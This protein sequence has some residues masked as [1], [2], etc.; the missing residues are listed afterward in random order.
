M[1]RASS[2]VWNVCCQT[3][4]SLRLRKNRFDDP[5]LFRRIR[6]DELLRQPI[7]PT[8]LPE[9]PTLEDQAVIAPARPAPP[10]AG[11][12]QTGPGRRLPPRAPPPLARLRQRELVADHFPIM[13]QSIT[14]A[15]CAQP[16]AHGNMRHPWPTVRCSDWPDS[17]SL[18]RAGGGGDTLMHEPPLLFQDPDRPLSDSREPLLAAQRHRS[19]RYPKVGYCWISCR[20]RSIT[21]DRPSGLAAPVRPVDAGPLG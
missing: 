13:R 14:A 16:S 2:N 5:I 20:S 6:C 21:A 11:A 9:P 12:S 19:R 7:V 4:S 3:H 10:Q 1:R 17:L 15:R 18:G 8:G